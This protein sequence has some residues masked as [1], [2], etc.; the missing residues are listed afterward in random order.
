MNRIRFIGSRTFEVI[1]QL[2]FQRVDCRSLSDGTLHTIYFNGK[3]KGL[4][5]AVT[6][7]SDM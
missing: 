2:H 5:N 6:Q 7:F 3:L 1:G 4:I